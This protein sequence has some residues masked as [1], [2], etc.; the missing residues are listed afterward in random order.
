M[1]VPHLIFENAGGFPHGH[2]PCAPEPYASPGASGGASYR[3]AGQ[4]GWYL[5]RT[6]LGRCGPC[7]G[8]AGGHIGRI[9]VG[10]RPMCLCTLVVRDLLLWVM[11]PCG[12]LDCAGGVPDG[13]NPCTTSSVVGGSHRPSR[14]ISRMTMLRTDLNSFCRES[15]RRSG[16]CS[17]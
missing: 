10:Y 2:P 15:G 3:C 16:N 4:P 14:S 12:I 1:A 7:C 17:E 6:A 11:C 13:V 9:R 8:I 5:R